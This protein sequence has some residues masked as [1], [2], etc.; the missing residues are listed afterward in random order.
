VSCISLFILNTAVV[1]TQSRSLVCCSKAVAHQDTAGWIRNCH[2][3]Y[4]AFSLCRLGYPYPDGGDENTGP[5][6]NEEGWK[7]NCYVNE[8]IDNFWAPMLESKLKEHG[9]L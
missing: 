1:H 6:W 8:K 5:K 2:R 9:V 4:S 3:N 7:Y